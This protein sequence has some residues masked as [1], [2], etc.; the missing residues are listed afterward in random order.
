MMESLGQTPFLFHY[1][2]SFPQY[3]ILN[4]YEAEES[5]CKEPI[6]CVPTLDVPSDLS[7]HTVYKVKV[8]DDE[9]LKLKARIAPHVNEGRLKREVISD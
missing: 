5:E 3:V 4:A 7:S 6:K 1:G 2:Q 9:K 8:L